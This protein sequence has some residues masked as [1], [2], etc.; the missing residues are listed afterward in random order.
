M[1]NGMYSIYTFDS[2]RG[3]E[4]FADSATGR[5]KQGIDQKYP[6]F[7]VELHNFPGLGIIFSP[8]PKVES[9]SFSDLRTSPKFIV[10]NIEQYEDLGVCAFRDVRTGKY[11][12]S[13]YDNDRV[14]N[15]A[16]YNKGWEKFTLYRSRNSLIENT[17]IKNLILKLNG[18]FFECLELINEED[19]STS[20]MIIH[21]LSS[22][23]S[24]MEKILENKNKI[25]NGYR[26]DNFIKKINENKFLEKYNLFKKSN[27]WNGFDT[28]SKELK[29]KI[30]EDMF[31]VKSKDIIMSF[32]TLECEGNRSVFNQEWTHSPSPELSFLSFPVGM[33]SG[34]QSCIL[35]RDGHVFLTEGSNQ[36]RKLCLMDEKSSEVREVAG[37]WINLIRTRKENIRKRGSKFIQIIVPEKVSALSNLFKGDFCG[38]T[39]YLKSIEK[40]SIQEYISCLD[41]FSKINSSYA[42]K[43]VDTH[44]Q[45]LGSFS[46]FNAISEKYFDKKFP[47]PNFS[48]QRLS[49]GDLS[50]RFF[51]HGVREII[52]E[53]VEDIN[54]YW[55]S[56]L[57]IEDV[58]PRPGAH[59]GQRNV[60]RNSN[61]LLDLKIVAFGNSFFGSG[62]DQCCLGW[63][64][65]HCCKEFH[66]FWSSEINYEYLDAINPDVVIC[67]T[68]ERFL[69]RVPNS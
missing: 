5:I 21:I 25:F 38:P 49:A 13:G 37:K 35:G 14:D 46:V 41:I 23:K 53:A 52:Y 50:Y 3:K 62:K 33:I 58:H 26:L 42:Y 4:I 47:F 68:A 43:K 55:G 27:G 40:E 69:G 8:D 7:L 11:L 45:P 20:E 6:L 61:A 34:D 48:Q 63:W 16:E 28:V 65:S 57:L 59:N 22:K 24:G 9:I 32:L 51:G 19:D 1:K 17:Y 2:F 39:A 12:R 36:L 60:W 66:H 44:L 29:Y 31:G 67:Q 64:F 18:D 30:F 56:R 54:F 10:V 15:M